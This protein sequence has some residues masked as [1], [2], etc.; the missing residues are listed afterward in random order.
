MQWQHWRN[1]YVTYKPHKSIQ[2][3]AAF[4]K[5]IMKNIG[6]N[7]LTDIKEKYYVRA[8]ISTLS[9]FNIPFRETQQYLSERNQRLEAAENLNQE[10]LVNASK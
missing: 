10:N 7:I 3:L 4:L 6:Q 5:I 1:P 9:L 2:D 8:L